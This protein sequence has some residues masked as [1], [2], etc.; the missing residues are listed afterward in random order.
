VG[1][2]SY[3]KRRELIQPDR[4]ERQ[5]TRLME[6]LAVAQAEGTVP[7]A[8]MLATDGTH[9]TR[10][11]TLIVITASTDTRWVT[12]LRGLRSRG[13]QGI[14][15]LSSGH[16]HQSLQHG[17]RYHVERAEDIDPEQDRSGREHPA[18]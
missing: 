16:G 15:A 14:G 4:G 2:L 5:L 7:I 17:I 3:P 10:Q 12:A 1:F 13:V 11:S 6:V 9:L 18:S 8:Q